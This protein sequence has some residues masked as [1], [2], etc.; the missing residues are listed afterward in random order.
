MPKNPVLCGAE[1]SRLMRLGLLLWLV[2]GHVLSAAETE[3]KSAFSVADVDWARSA[4]VVKG[5]RQDVEQAFVKERLQPVAPETSRQE[6]KLDEGWQF[7]LV[8]KQPVAVGTALLSASGA[9]SSH[10]LA[11]VLRAEFKGPVDSKKDEQ[12]K[13]EHWR[14]VSR[15]QTFEADFRASALRLTARREYRGPLSWLLLSPRLMSLTEV[16]VGSGEKAPFG[17]HPNAIPLGQSWV[18]T[19]K[20]P[21]PGAAKQLQRG[22]VSNATPSWYIL[23]WDEPQTLDALW[24][25]S[26]ADEFRLLAYH[27]DEGLNPA[28]APTSAWARLEFQTPHEQRGG[29]ERMTDR[30]LSFAPLKTTALK[31]EMTNCR[32]GATAAISQMAAM[33]LASRQSDSKTSL[34]GGS[35]KKTSSDSVGKGIAFEQP[36]DGQLAMVITDREGR[37]IRNLV[38]QVDRQKGANVEHWDLKDQTGLTV[39]PGT[40]R[41]KAITSPPLGLRYQISVY[42]NAPQLFPGMTPWLTGE[43]G[44]NG[45]LADHAPITSGAVSGDRL[46]FGAPGVEAGVCL[47]EC[48]L[49]GRK[50]WGKHSFGPFAGV[51]ML[52][53]DESHLYIQERDSLHRLDPLT[54]KLERLAALSTP[55]R[56]GHVTSMAAH[57][58][59]V[60]VAQSSPIPWLEN[61]TRADVVDLENS[62]PK[63]AAKIPDPLGTRRVQ[64]NPR[65][66]FLRLLRLMGTPAGQGAVSADKRESI[67]PITI[68]TTGEGKNQ[69]IV[70]AFK[71]PVPLGSLVLPCIGPEFLVD[72]SV[73]K[74]SASY[75]P[76]PQKDSDWQPCP[77]KPRP[78]W[79]C[80]PMPPQVRTQG[81][82]IRVRRASDA[83]EEDLIDDLLTAK[84]DK[85]KSDGDLD[86]DQPS[87]KT[88]KPKAVSEFDIDKPSGLGKGG[89]KLEV[90]AAANWFARFDG[91]KLLR[92]RFTDITAQAKVRVNSGEVNARGEWDA[93]RTEALSTEKPGI[94]V[95]E[96]AEVK[97]VTGLAIK[98]IDGALTEIDVWDGAEKSGTIPLDDSPHWR[99]VATYEQSRRDSYHPAFERNDAA[100]YLD[101]YVSL[102][103]EVS[104]RAVRLRVVSQ[105]ADNGDRGTASLRIDQGGRDLDPRRCRIA[106][107]AALEYLGNEAPLDEL[108]YERL[109]VRDGKTG[110]VLREVS[111]KPA[112]YLEVSKDG[113]SRT[114]E[115]S[116]DGAD[117]SLT[118]SATGLSTSAAPSSLSFRSDGALFGIQNGRVVR[119]DLSSGTA[120]VEL[121]EIDGL[122]QFAHRLAIGPDGAFHV[123]VLP[124]KV[125]QVF[126]RAGQ[127]LRTLGHPGGHVPGPWDPEK[128]GQVEN[129][130]VDR[131]GQ[132]WVV[133]SQDV[134]RRI[135]QFNA[136]GQLVREFYGNTHYGGGG[137][138]DPADKSRL[139]YSHLEF[140]IDWKTGQSRIKNMLAQWLPE[141]LVP[142]RNKGQTYLVSTP[143]SHQSTQP[144]VVVYRY[145]ES[146]GLA[147]LAA[148]FGEANK[149]DYLKTP[150][151]LSK[152]ASGKVPKD[153]LFVWSDRSGDGAVDPDEVSFELKADASRMLRLG[154]C[155]AQLRCWAGAR[156]Y[157]PQSVLPNGVP[158]FEHVAA[159]GSR[160]GSF[161]LDSGDLLALSAPSELPERHGDGR[162][163]E[164]RGIDR[165]GRVKWRYPTEH[166]SVSGLYLPPWEPGYVSNEFGVIGHA[167]AR[168]GDL[169]EFVVIHGNNGMWKVW[170]ADGLLAGQITRHKFDPRSIVDSSR[171]TVERDQAFNNLTAGQ[172]HFHGY[173]TQSRDGRDYIVHGFNYIGLWEVTGLDEFKRLTGEVIVTPDDVRQVRAQHEELARREAKS[174]AR[175]LDCVP[176][177]TSDLPDVAELDDI[178]FGIGYDE[179]YLYARWNVAR[180]GRL[181]NS[182]T[183]Y[184]RYFKTGACL[185]LQLGVDQAANPSRR[186]PVAGDMRLLFTV[187]EGQPQ[188]VLYQPIAEGASPQEAWETRTDAGGTTRFDRVVR[189]TSA[190]L[191]FIPD[192]KQN[193]RYVFN[194]AIPLK[195]LRWKPRDGQLLRCDWGVLTSDDG[196][197]VKRR[198]YWS[199]PLATGTT[200]EAWEARLDPHLWGT[201]AVLSASRAD[202]QLELSSPGA[203]P[204]TNSATDLLDDILNSADSKKK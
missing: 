39:A 36:F 200:D 60:V 138:L 185:D 134:P 97:K 7:T 2:A 53:G 24:L 157:Q 75:P 86:L 94:Y 70:L 87:S 136:A 1:R 195:E 67:F 183:D 55:E 77:E 84:T 178:H 170:T 33:S 49:T 115:S 160:E 68:D 63:F 26:N 46:F 57:K 47:I 202:R 10:F 203:K 190:K 91:L 14:E 32:R 175:V 141:D 16:A 130:L 95:L 126:D 59:Q 118:T 5:E 140:A 90:D 152:L 196:H 184:R 96:W 18:N 110:E 98:E 142:V 161:E 112:K 89:P 193:D 194:A 176:V 23:A 153:Y 82:R 12:A 76:N 51:G 133:E 186:A 8:F 93:K 44:A 164:T 197:T 181:S 37:T 154:R 201:L 3:W 168:K 182:G 137:V 132:T 155:N 81:L 71:E 108:T 149:F 43:S 56:K 111:V 92:R 15:T 144:A 41:W 22:P 103:G 106:G 100:R 66:D 45:W 113:R 135:V 74:P 73:L 107:V 131:S 116:D 9:E 177:K 13:S 169:G 64:P 21:R 159:S 191:Q 80:V 123:Y 173:F 119:I 167:T 180:Q 99:K 65:V 17:S 105:W 145:D 163:Q 11:E 174:Q 72:V 30:L 104:T 188:A 48:D 124:E 4:I 120:T 150:S 117:R 29:G 199:N 35:Q 179:Q 28:V 139:F 38:A 19:D 147:T 102:G 125:I 83:G 121:P 129:V 109:E 34:A 148:A 27:G 62:L 40:Y 172:E 198:L 156:V 151:I 25:S 52:A 143:L 158:V 54:H 114:R 204:K 58:G 31:V 79:T 171:S 162:A 128:F 85:K 166:P 88:A 165:E 69:Y 187:A 189:L 78:G 122:K 192:D 20:D 101:G 6:V 146:R 61:A 127:R 42:P 50:L